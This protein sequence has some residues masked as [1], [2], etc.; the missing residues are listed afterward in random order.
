MIGFIVGVL[1]ALWTAVFLNGFGHILEGMAK[2]GN[3][4]YENLFAGIDPPI[5][6]ALLIFLTVINI[7]AQFVICSTIGTYIYN[8]V[9]HR[10]GGITIEV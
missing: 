10:I 4:P 8:F 9:A 1:S 2:S 7:T 3:L 6:L 5:R